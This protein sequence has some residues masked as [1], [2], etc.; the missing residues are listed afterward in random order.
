MA[1]A[2]S[3]FSQLAVRSSIRKGNVSQ[4]NE[5]C[6]RLVLTG[7][8]GLVIALDHGLAELGSHLGHRF[9]LILKL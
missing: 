8:G 2:P 4:R 9:S 3:L 1:V 5:G 6:A 7:S